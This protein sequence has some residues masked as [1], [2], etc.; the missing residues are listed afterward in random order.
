MM[1]RSILLCALVLAL[2]CPP[3]FAETVFDD[4]LYHTIDYF[5]DDS[6]T[7]SGTAPDYTTVEV[8]PDGE[9]SD[10]VTLDTAGQLYSNV[11]AASSDSTFQMTSG[12]VYGSVQMTGLST[13]SISSS[14]IWGGLTYTASSDAFS[15]NDSYIGG[16]L[17]TAAT[18]NSIVSNT[19]VNGFVTSFGSPQVR[20]ENCVL[21]SG[22]EASNSSVFT[23]IDTGVV[24]TIVS[25][26]SAYVYIYGQNFNV[27]GIDDYYGALSGF[28]TGT[29]TGSSLDG[30]VINFD[31]IIY[32]DAEIILVPEPA[33]MLLFGLGCLL[34]RSVAKMQARRWLRLSS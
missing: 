33:T 20:L 34:R 12:D 32:E 7:V 17:T 24:G 29:V 14:N 6:L 18:N 15:V 28:G 21:Y 8:T 23:L 26:T 16:N 31:F 3:S 30:D 1:K 22:I 11:Y 25:D 5:L 27:N 19:T 2:T 10:D 9:I 13:L 4:G